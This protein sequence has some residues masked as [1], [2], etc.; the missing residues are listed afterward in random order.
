[1]TRF[2]PYEKK[3]GE[4]LVNMLEKELTI[5]ID[6]FKLAGI[7]A[8]MGAM[9]YII[10]VGFYIFVALLVIIGATVFIQL[11]VMGTI[12]K[13]FERTNLI[14]AELRERDT[15]PDPFLEMHKNLVEV[16]KIINKNTKRKTNDR[17]K[18]TTKKRK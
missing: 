1:M 9:Y 16:K 18:T 8:I 14:V 5:S 11:I 6:A 15:Q 7:T 2:R 3:T 4:E 12:F 10:P 13:R 17:K